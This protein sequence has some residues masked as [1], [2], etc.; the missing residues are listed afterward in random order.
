MKFKINK[1]GYSIFIDSVTTTKISVYCKSMSID[2]ISLR[3]DLLEILEQV[4]GE[5]KNLKNEG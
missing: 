5:I 2:L 1:F 4:E 3:K